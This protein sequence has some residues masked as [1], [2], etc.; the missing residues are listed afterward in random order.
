MATFTG[1]RHSGNIAPS[2]RVID[3]DKSIHL[4]EPSAAPLT[5]FLNRLSKKS[6][7]SDSTFKWHEDELETR[8]DAVN[9][10]GGYNSSAGTITV[11]TSSVFPA[12]SLVRVTRTGEILY[13]SDV[14]GDDLEVERGFGDSSAAAINDDDELFLI[15]YAA[16]E[17]DT[18]VEPR[19]AN[20]VPRTNY[21]Q[22]F[23]RTVEQ[24]G[25]LLSSSNESNPHDWPYQLKKAGIEHQK[26]KEHAFLF[27]SP[28]EETVDGKPVRTTGGVLHYAT[29]NNQDAGGTWTEAEN[30]T[31]MRTV[32][33][34]GSSS[35][36]LFASPLL[37]SVI[38][39]Y[40]L[41]KVQTSV[42]DTIYGV[43]VMSYVSAHGELKIVK[44]N[45][46]EGAVWGGYGIVV[47]F[48]DDA[49]KYRY[50]NGSGPGGSRDTKLLTDREENDRDG[51]RSEYL[52]EAGLQVGNSE[53]H[54]VI[55]GVTG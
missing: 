18:S 15:G 49:L 50:L 6:P 3:M 23:K 40:S 31:F 37:V 25:T 39:N 7:A 45:L 34:H 2:Q 8:F 27:G 48:G 55:T 1:Q 53:R 26:D 13:V 19:S 43:K 5:V 30:E 54:G 11:D 35:K 17:G 38:N 44:H 14:S 22:I 46:L 32:F 47:D 29:S 21:T 20:P 10:G 52:T 24:S 16:R 41:S 51:K 36:V 4:L 12:Q 9:N 33:R 42:G 28:G